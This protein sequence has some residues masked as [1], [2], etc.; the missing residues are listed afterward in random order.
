MKTADEKKCVLCNVWYDTGLFEGKNNI[1]SM[2]WGSCPPGPPPRTNADGCG[3]Y[4][5]ENSCQGRVTLQDSQLVVLIK[6]T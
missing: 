3:A 2:M 4:M 1:L 6:P 5:P